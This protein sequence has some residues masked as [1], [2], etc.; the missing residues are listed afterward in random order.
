MFSRLRII[1][2]ARSLHGVEKRY[3]LPRRV[4]ADLSQLPDQPEG[5][6]GG[7]RA[8]LL[9]C[10]MAMCR[11]IRAPQL[12]RLQ[13]KRAAGLTPLGKPGGDVEGGTERREI[14]W[15]RYADLLRGANS[16]MSRGLS[17]SSIRLFEAMCAGRAPVILADQWVPPP[18]EMGEL[19]PHRAG[20]DVAS[21][22]R[23]LE[24]EADA[25]EMGC[26]RGANGTIFSPGCFSPRGGALPGDPEIADDAEWLGGS[27]HPTTSA[28]AKLKNIVVGL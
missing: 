10:F 2:F 21:V 16:A 18:A 15:E 7:R 17:P 26:W 27:D 12:A 11:L 4:R 14:Y 25:A 5:A 28:L 13:H 23:L 24:R 19:Q 22:P 3:Y 20:R 8:D 9:Y 1:R 6:F